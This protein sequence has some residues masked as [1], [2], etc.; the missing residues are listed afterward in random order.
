MFERV[1]GCAPHAT[2]QKEMFTTPDL[3]IQTLVGFFQSR[4]S[5]VQPYTQSSALHDLFKD[6]TEK[7]SRLQ[8]HQVLHILF[9]IS[10]KAERGALW[11]VVKFLGIPS[12]AEVY[13]RQLKSRRRNSGHTHVYFREKKRR[14]QPTD[15]WDKPTGNEMISTRRTEVESRSLE[16]V[17]IKS[18][19][20]YPM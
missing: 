15:S 13:C 11:V 5:R 6:R 18:F 14:K 16:I 3:K 2:V 20:S 19:S 7:F 1:H 17:L 9:P 4:M 10:S 12:D 8:S